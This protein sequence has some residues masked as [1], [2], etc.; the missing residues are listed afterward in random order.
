MNILLFRRFL[1]LAQGA[2]RLVRLQA[3]G[4]KGAG[5][6]VDIACQ[7]GSL[8]FFL[9]TGRRARRLNDQQIQSLNDARDLLVVD[10]DMELPGAA[11][12]FMH[13]LAA[14]A[15][16]FVDSRDLESTMA[17]ERSFFARLRDDAVLVANSKMVKAALIEHFGLH[18]DRIVVHYPGYSRAQ[19]SSSRVER[20]RKSARRALSLGEEI[21]L[22]G[23]L[24][25]GELVKHGLD[26]FLE[27]AEQITAAMPQTRF[28][29]LGVKEL[30]TLAARHPLVLR[31]KVLHRPGG[32]RPELWMSALDVF[33]Y[34]ARFE[35]FGM[36]VSQ[37]QALGLPVLTSRRVGAAECM[38]EAY[39]PWLLDKP[40]GSRF[41]RNAIALLA[42]PNLRRDLGNVGRSNVRNFDETHYARATVETIQLRNR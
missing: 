39:R 24:T 41:A 15:G 10:H 4:L 6:Q 28:L 18:P 7:A 20:L 19:F 23:M 22:V 5:M 16:R 21:P 1:D 36:A 42:D 31:G 12:I 13:I 29:V 34:P 38:P 9:R 2:G 11:V 17:K 14:A 26:T 32:S 3:E 27:C 8:K 30:P 35:E 33:L 25:S 37:A 40:E